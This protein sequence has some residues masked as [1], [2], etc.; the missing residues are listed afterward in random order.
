MEKMT[1]KE[2]AIHTIIS[3]FASKD[4]DGHWVNRW[5]DGYYL[6]ERVKMITD[7]IKEKYY[8][9]EKSKID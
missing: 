4:S 5:K 7:Y 1:D 2:Y 8:I 6:D 3:Q 9:I